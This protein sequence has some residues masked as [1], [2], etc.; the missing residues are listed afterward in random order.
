MPVPRHTRITGGALDVSGGIRTTIIGPAR[1]ELS[2][3]VGRLVRALG[4]SGTSV[5]GPG[6]VLKISCP[7]LP[8]GSPALEDDESYQLEV[9]PALGIELTA[10]QPAGVVRGLSTAAQL[11]QPRPDGMKMLCAR[12]EDRPR[13]AW[14]GL[15]IDSSRHFIT[16]PVLLRNLDA[17]AAVK[18]NVLHWHLCDDQGFRMECQRYPRLHEVGGEDLYYTRQEVE[19][20]VQHAADRRIRVVPEFDLPGHASSWLAAYPH[21]GCRRE[22]YA[23]ARGWG[24]HDACLDPTRDEVFEFLDGF[25]GEVLPLF[26]DE[27]VHIG[28]DEVTGTE[29]MA[30]PQVVA[31]MEREELDVAGVQTRFCRRLQGIV[32]KHGKRVVGW[33]E[34]AGL[35]EGA[36][37][38]CWRGLGSV[39]SAAGAGCQVIQS[40]G[41]YLDSLDRAGQFYRRDPVAG[42]GG[43]QTDRVLG[44]E[45]CMWTEYADST[46]IDSRI[47]PRAAAVAERLWSAG[48]VVD[49]PDMYRRLRLVSR[50]LEE[51]GLTHA[52]EL[53]TR[54]R[55]LVVSGSGESVLH[56]F[57]VLSPARLDR[58]RDRLA[59][60]D[61]VVD[62]LPPES[63]V[64]HRFAELVGEFLEDPGCGAGQILRGFLERWVEIHDRL[65]RDLEG[66]AALAE[67]SPLSRSLAELGRVGLSAVQAIASP[68]DTLLP[69]LGDDG[70][71]PK[72]GDFDLQ[73]VASVQQ[74]VAAAQRR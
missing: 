68:G 51:L 44:G 12:I 49:E 1:A 70:V 71:A 37:V 55:R 4:G 16:L 7:G 63:G 43:E 38:Q 14:R 9:D 28:G 36:T 53:R 8:G 17:M 5:A 41:F 52:A 45:A 65:L 25:F 11:M 61:S 39:E 35:G 47:W 64:A 46:T 10:Q 26:P 56:L 3:A 30:D 19:T 6:A 23:L 18:L 31:L 62:A 13:F 60:L 2:G 20:V 22:G 29:W 21:L 33:E 54:V 34:V 72:H 73:I 15:L 48:E 42:L 24:P 32:S 66:T 67:L 27:Y 40:H 50:R 74:L 57:A 58:V 69:E 59:P